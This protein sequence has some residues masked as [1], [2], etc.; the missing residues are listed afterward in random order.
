MTYASK[1]GSSSEGSSDEVTVSG[2]NDDFTAYFIST[3]TN[4]GI[5]FKTATVI[6]GTKTS[7]GI[8]NYLNAF[9]LLEKGADP[10]GKLMG[11]NEF[12]IFKDNNN[13]ASNTTW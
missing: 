10:N 7:S 5:S 12:R 2:S 8:K 3:G 1:Q 11:V 4:S 6:S 9:I 13:L